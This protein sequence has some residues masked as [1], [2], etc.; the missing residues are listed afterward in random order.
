MSDKNVGTSA[1]SPRNLSH[2]A[3]YAAL[4]AVIFLG[5]VALAHFA[6]A[7]IDRDYWRAVWAGVAYSGWLIAAVATVAEL[8]GWRR[9]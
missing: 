4:V 8:A 9:G 7:L 2:I 1:Q 3:L 6:F 5:A